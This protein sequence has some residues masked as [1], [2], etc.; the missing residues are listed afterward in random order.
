MLDFN[1]SSMSSTQ[2][3]ASKPK[4]A[5][6]NRLDLDS[7]LP[8]RFYKASPLTSFLGKK[9]NDLDLEIFDDDFD[10]NPFPE[11]DSVEM[12]PNKKK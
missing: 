6:I 1:K 5:G 10:Q 12:N 8:G 11:R 4:P 3:F 2:G 9:R 7:V